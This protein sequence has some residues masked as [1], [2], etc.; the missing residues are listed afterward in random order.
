MLPGSDVPGIIGLMVEWCLLN[1]DSYV[2]SLGLVQGWAAF[3]WLPSA[4]WC[5]LPSLAINNIRQKTLL[6]PKDPFSF[7][8]WASP[9]LLSGPQLFPLHDG[10]LGGL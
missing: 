6:D 1:I 5:S 2:S 10:H 9:S 4:Q 3:S 8:P 7:Q